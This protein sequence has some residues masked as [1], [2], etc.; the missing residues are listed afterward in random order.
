MHQVRIDTVSLIRVLFD[1]PH[2]NDMTAPP[3]VV[4]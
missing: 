2:F 3:Q 4:I 1:L